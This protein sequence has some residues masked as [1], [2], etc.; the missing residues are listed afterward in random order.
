[1][2]ADLPGGFRNNWTLSACFSLSRSKDTGNVPEKNKSIYSGTIHYSKI[3]Q[4]VNVQHLLQA[5]LLKRKLLSWNNFSSKKEQASPWQRWAVNGVP[6]GTADTDVCDALTFPQGNYQQAAWQ[7]SPRPDPCDPSPSFV[8]LSLCVGLYRQGQGPSSEVQFWL[9]KRWNSRMKHAGI[10]RRVTTDLCKDPR[11]WGVDIH[12]RSN[13]PCTALAKLF[14][15]NS[16]CSKVAFNTDVKLHFT[17]HDKTI[18]M[19]NG[20]NP[21]KI[22]KLIVFRQ[23]IRNWKS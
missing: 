9:Q 15:H 13:S 11:P 17:D 6:R 23:H 20:W 19:P 12:A 10:Q 1:M 16:N 4:Y 18:H 21:S 14:Q 7:P 3:P 2:P 5:K 22:Y 8:F